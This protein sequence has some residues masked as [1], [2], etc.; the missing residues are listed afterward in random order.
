M[1]TFEY[2]FDILPGKGKD[3]Q[4]YLARAGKDIWFKFPGVRAAP[5]FA[6]RAL[7]QDLRVHLLAGEPRPPGDLPGEVPG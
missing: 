4:K 3:Y 6:H 2:R 1:I 7:L 5:L